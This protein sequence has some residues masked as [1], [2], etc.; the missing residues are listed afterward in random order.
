MEFVLL[1]Q[2]ALI[3]LQRHIVEE[4]VHVKFV[5]LATTADV[6]LS[7]LPS[8]FLHLLIP[9]VLVL[10]TLIV[11]V[12]LQ[13]HIAEGQEHVYSVELAIIVGVQLPRLPNVHPL[14]P[15]HALLALLMQT[16]LISLQLLTVKEGYAKSARHPI[17]LV[18]AHLLL[19]NL[20]VLQTQLVP[21]C[22]GSV[23]LIKIVL[24]ENFAALITLVYL[25]VQHPPLRIYH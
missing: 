1:T 25:R 20:N 9:V 13:L 3:F 16:V 5:E 8:V 19:L 10:S 23:T 22:V 15:M 2:I 12:F 11:L 7:Q 6:L 4:Q 14:L 17:T 24:L 18:A 21:I